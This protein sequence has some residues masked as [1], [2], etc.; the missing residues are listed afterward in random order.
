MNTFPERVSANPTTLHLVDDAIRM[1]SRLFSLPGVASPDWCDRAAQAVA[2]EVPAA[3]V[4][5]AIV[6]ML[7]NGLVEKP[8][9]TGT[10]GRQELRAALPS[11]FENMRRHAA[12]PGVGPAAVV[13]PAV[14]AGPALVAQPWTT[15]AGMSAWLTVARAHA[16]AQDS[17]GRCVFVVLAHGPHDNQSVQPQDV[18]P[19]AHAAASVLATIVRGFGS[20]D[21]AWITP[22]E[23]EVLELLVLGYS[24][25]EI[26]EKLNRSPHTIHDYVKSMHRKLA[27]GNR[28]ALVARALGQHRFAEIELKPTDAV[29][30]RSL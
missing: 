15:I 16:D 30:P 1:A 3:G 20:P 21:I 8:L 12:A 23:Q 24:V 5:I 7:P 29:A 17:G 22:R 19:K 2:R 10:A 6:R 26:G 14:V 11:V 25:R 4:G 27:E 28:G 9:A 18:V 13:P